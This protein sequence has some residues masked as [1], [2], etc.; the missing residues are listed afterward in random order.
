MRM[1]QDHERGTGPWQTEPL[2]IPQSFG[3]TAGALAHARTIAAGMTVDTRRMRQNL[4]ATGGLIMA[5]AAATALTPIIGRAAAEEA[6][7]Q[8]CNRDK[9]S[10]A[11]N[12]ARRSDTQAASF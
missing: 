4:D 2:V 1:V 9:S 7:A 5:E 11:R 10:F 6:V 3:L 8:A 12:V